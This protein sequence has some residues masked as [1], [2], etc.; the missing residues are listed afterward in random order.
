MA[1]INKFEKLMNGLGETLDNLEKKPLSTTPKTAPGQLMAFRNESIAYEDKIKALELE[2][3]DAKRTEINVDLIDPN[4]WQ[5]R[6]YFNP[7]EIAELAESISEL[8]LIQPIIVRRTKDGLD[9]SVP[10]WNTSERFQLVAGERRLRAHKE[11]GRTEIK[12]IVIE[13]ADEELAVMALAENV[14]RADL[15]DYEIS[16][17]INRAESEFKNRAKMAKAIGMG[18]TDLYRYI[19]FKSLPEAIINDLEINPRLLGRAAAE[20][21]A[22]LIKDHGAAAT[23]AIIKT[24]PKIKEGNLD[25]GKLAAAAESIMNGKAART[26]RDIR[27]LFVNTVQAGSITRDENSF[28]VKIKTLLLTEEKETKLREFVQQLLEQ[29]ADKT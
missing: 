9:K 26:D 8:G 2:L 17:A 1:K 15:A 24:W 21:V 7:Q 13:A 16:K 29:D 11:L 25:E 4:P 6:T 19:S 23:E 20:Q 14:D 12:A 22:K 28:T 5:P 10:S 18:R 3:A 27:K